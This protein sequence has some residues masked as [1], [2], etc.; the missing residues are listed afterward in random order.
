[1]ASFLE[2]CL[3]CFFLSSDYNVLVKLSDSLLEDLKLL[4]VQPRGPEKCLLTFKKFILPKLYDSLFPLY[5]CDVC[6][7]FLSFSLFVS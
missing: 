6:S 3:F 5:K 4:A 7:L 2:S 1:V